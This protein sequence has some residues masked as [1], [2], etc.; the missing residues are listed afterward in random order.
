MRCF[1]LLA[2][3]TMAHIAGAV[4]S[5]DDID[6]WV[7]EGANCAG[8]A[9]DWDGD[10]LAPAERP[11]L[12]WGYRW[13]GVATGED[14]LRAVLAADPRLFAKLSAGGQFGVATYGFGYQQQTQQAFALVDGTAFDQDG[15]AITTESDGVTAS[16]ADDWYEEGWIF[17]FWHY[18]VSS[19]PTPNGWTTSG[20]GPTSRMLTSGAW[21]S[22]AH[23]PS[24]SLGAFADGLTAAE[25]LTIAGDYNANGVV[26]AADYS[27]WRD[28]VGA[29]GPAD[30]NHDGVV[31]QLDYDIWRDHFGSGSAGGCNTN[32]N[33]A[34]PEGTGLMLGVL[35][36]ASVAV[37]PTRSRT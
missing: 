34:V 6:F 20:I 32:N 18:G 22:Y 33:V 1:A 17:S 5:F 30:G 3:M 26:D 23:S 10:N 16:N 11:A 12:V 36:V 7:G 28:S 27:V 4:S 21:D 19:G 14:M 35:G 29:T 9:I 25:P 8:L 15:V 13:N 31:D 37:W 24:F 2:T